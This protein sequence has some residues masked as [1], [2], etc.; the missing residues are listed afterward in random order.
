MTVVDR[1]IRRRKKVR[2]DGIILHANESFPISDNRLFLVHFFLSF[3]LVS[4]TISSDSFSSGRLRDIE[5]VSIS[6]PRYVILE[7]G[8]TCLS[9]ANGT[10]RVG[11]KFIVYADLVNID[12]NPLQ[13]EKNR[14][15][16]GYYYEYY[17][18]FA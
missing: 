9:A 5:V 12:Y 14:L 18:C 10:P 16:N 13:Q 3:H 1:S 2:P 11:N 8:P 6:I 15:N 4:R 17:N 7:V